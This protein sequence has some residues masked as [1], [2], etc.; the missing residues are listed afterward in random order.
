MHYVIC[1]R[2]PLDVAASLEARKVEPLPPEQGVGL[3]LAYVRAALAAT[4]GHPRRLIFYE[5][6]MADP[7]PVVRRLG[8]FIGRDQST[9]PTH[10]P[11]PQSMWR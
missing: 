2:N 11:A 8:S 7:E 5:D 10:M 4:T 1:L 6:L 9:S 3:W